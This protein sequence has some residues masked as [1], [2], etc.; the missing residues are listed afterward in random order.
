MWM[1]TLAVA[2]LTATLGCSSS[3]D[4]LFGDPQGGGGEGEGGDGV[5]SASV[6]GGGP[7]SGGE[8]QGAGGQ[9]STTTSG[10]G[11]SG[12]SAGEGGSAGDGGSTST[13]C[14]PQECGGSYCGQK[15]DGCGGMA[16]CPIQCSPG[17]Q[18][19]QDNFC[20]A[21]P[22]DEGA[23]CAAAGAECGGVQANV[24]G[25]VIVVGCGVPSQVCGPLEFCGASNRCEGCVLGG[26]DVCGAGDAKPHE[27][28]CP[29][30]YSNG[31]Q[32]GLETDVD[33]GGPNHPKRCAVG[34]SCSASSDCKSDACVN[35]TCAN[36]NFPQN[37]SCDWY[38]NAGVFC[39]G[40]D[41]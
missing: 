18:C 10:G 15:P 5:G 3:V 6:D 27:W 17:S 16:Q 25:Q 21:C 39:C 2:V 30:F 28:T 24:C 9:G 11:G 22:V 20:A 19:G 14:V 41:G 29:S 4:D 26:P 8:A 31:I 37:D 12:G 13:G 34:D 1:K 40:F 33:C 32:D 35:G 23:I 36:S 7:G 38:G